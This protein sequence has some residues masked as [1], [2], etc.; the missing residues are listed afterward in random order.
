M[1]TPAP[2]ARVYPQL[3][4][5]APVPENCDELCNICNCAAA[6]GMQPRSE[7]GLRKHG[8]RSA[9]RSPI[10]GVMGHMGGGGGSTLVDTGGTDCGGDNLPW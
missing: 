2:K 3:I 10:V 1:L 7:N 9:A 8:G 5:D 4:E 6:G